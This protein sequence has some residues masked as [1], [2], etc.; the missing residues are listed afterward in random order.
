MARHPRIQIFSFGYYGWG[1]STPQLVQAVDAVERRRGFKPPIFV[2]IRIR[3]AVRAPG[4]NGNAFEKLL[5][6][7]RHRWMKALGNKQIVN[8]TGPPIQIAEPSAVNDLLDLAIVAAEDRRRLIFFC[9]CAWPRFQG[10]V[11]CHRTR[12]AAL[13][14]KAAE[15]RQLD[16]EVVEWPGG[17]ASLMDLPIDSM[18]FDGLMRDRFYVPAGRLALAQSAAIAWGSTA[19]ITADGQHVQAVIGPAQFRRGSWQLP[20][21]FQGESHSLS[22]IRRESA[23]VRKAYGFE[24]I[25]T[26]QL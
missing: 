9:S 16:V 15:R 21:L 19:T 26:G 13:A 20:I 11:K 8:R 17:K 24:P 7:K 1:N 18:S 2:D 6:E 10:R 12:V 5:G 3:R 14:I 25:A 4:F 23:K 22:D